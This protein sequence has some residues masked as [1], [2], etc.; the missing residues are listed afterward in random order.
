MN[1]Y[2]EYHNS[3]DDKGRMAVPSD[4]RKANDLN[5]WVITKGMDGCLLLYDVDTWNSVVTGLKEKLSYKNEKDRMFMRFFLYPA[6]KVDLDKQ[7]R[8]KIPKSLLEWGKIKNKAV[9]L[10]AVQKI[11]I[12]AEENWEEYNQ[13]SSDK[14]E[15][16]MD[17]MVSFDF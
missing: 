6:K 9:V 14:I 8:V 13:V 5:N 2:G 15:E 4:F 12:W 17:S 11:E 10:G 1:F 7:G 16:V 3:L